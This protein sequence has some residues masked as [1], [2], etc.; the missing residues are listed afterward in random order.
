[1]AEAPKDPIPLA[2][3]EAVVNVCGQT[4]Y[5]KSTL[6]TVFRRSGVAERALDKYEQQFSK[7]QIARH[8]L[9]DLERVGAKGWIVQRRIVR[10]LASLDGPEDKAPDHAAG[11]RALETLRR[12]ALKERLL[13]DPAEAERKQR[14]AEAATEAEK[15]DRRSTEL[16][17]LHELFIA[18]HSESNHQARGF[19]L[20]RLM[21]DLFRLY[22]LEYNGSYRTDTDQID[23]SVVLDSFTYLLEARWRENK[24]NDADLGGLKHKV[25]RR[26]DATRGFYL[27]MAGYEDDAVALY[28]LAQEN[29]LIMLDGSDLLHMLEQRPPLVEGLQEKVKAA[30]TRGEPY[31]RLAD[32]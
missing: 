1:M 22:E 9:D 17:K 19:A 26:L 11:T 14:R 2:V 30:S 13:V 32:P 27:S 28:R 25:E 5:W 12:V 16:Q 10:E 8:I 20:E 18:L 31:L 7:F 29:K 23:G 15:R 6:R 24:A 3:Y 21:R 4:L